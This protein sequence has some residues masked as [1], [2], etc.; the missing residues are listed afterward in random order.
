MI[1]LPFL[2]PTATLENAG[3]KGASLARLTRLSLPVPPGFIVTT[4]AYRTFVTVNNLSSVITSS[5]AGVAADNS[6]E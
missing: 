1:I 6:T 4:E 5:I 3:G 2:S